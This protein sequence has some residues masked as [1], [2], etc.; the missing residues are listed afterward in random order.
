MNE[1]NDKSKESVEILDAQTVNDR[2][3]LYNKIKEMSNEERQMLLKVMQY[4][5]LI[6]TLQAI[7]NLKNTSEDTWKN[8]LNK[9]KSLT[10]FKISNN[11]F[12]FNE[13]L[14]KLIPL[15]A[16][17]AGCLFAMREY[18]EASIDAAKPEDNILTNK[19]IDALN[20]EKI[21]NMNKKKSVILQQCDKKENGFTL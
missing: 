1:E 18:E 17:L 20:N 7:K 9:L 12:D 21:F 6:E 10:N 13:S 2:I 16:A 4:N 11:E 14:K 15:V 19:K 8:I 5:V 3:R